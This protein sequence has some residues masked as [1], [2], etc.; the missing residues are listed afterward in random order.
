MYS[1][2]YADRYWQAANPICGYDVLAFV[3]HTTAA[4]GTPTGQRSPTTRDDPS[5]APGNLDLTGTGNVPIGW[6]W[7]GAAQPP[8]A[9]RLELLDGVSPSG[10]RA[11]QIARA[12]APWPWGVGRLEREFLAEAWR[13]KRL[14]FSAAVRAEVE[15]QRGGAHLYIAARSKPTE[16]ALWP[17]PYNAL[18]TL[19]RPLRSP[20]WTA[21]A[22]EI[23]I[24]QDAHTLTLGC[25]F[26]GDGAGWFSDL[27]VTVV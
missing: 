23:D 19:A 10:G 2:E 5:A 12:S 1:A 9:H 3:E 13:G 16:A 8:H 14:R 25:A 18:G 7:V 21:C 22:A 24:P 27:D 4:R 11:A 17:I 15:G 20:R 26:A 6:K